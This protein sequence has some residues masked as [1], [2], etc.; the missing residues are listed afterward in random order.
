M[1]YIPH[2]GADGGID[3][4]F[5]MVTDITERKRAEAANAR[6]AAI[7]S[8]SPDAVMSF[9]PDGLI[10]SWNAAAESLFDYTEAEA[11]GAYA[12]LLV[13]PGCL[14]GPRGV[15]DWG[16]AGRSVQVETTRLHKDGTRIDVAISAAPM[17]AASGAIIGVS[18][19]MRDIRARKRTDGALRESEQRL[20]TTYEHARVG[21][22]EVDVNGR[23]LRVNEQLCERT[24]YS[25]DEL[26]GMRFTD[27]TDP[28]DLGSDLEQFGR[29]VAGETN[30]Y[31]LE[32][33]FRNRAGQVFWTELCASIV[34]DDT[35]APLYIVRVSRDISERKRAEENLQL[36]VHELNHRVK[37]TL[38]TVQAIAAQTLRNT[39][40]PDQVQEALAARLMSLAQ[41]HDV[42]TRESW[43][44]ADLADIVEDAIKVHQ[45]CGQARIR[46][47]G[48]SIKVEPRVALSL[49]MALHE[50]ATNATKYGALS[51]E[52]GRV[53]VG[54]RV[55]NQGGT[56]RL[57]LRWKESGGPPVATPTRK[58]FGSRL[59]KRSLA[60][61]LG[62][63]A[64]IAYRP[65]GVVA[66]VS[67]P[68]QVLKQRLGR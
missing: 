16:L 67:A 25:R 43:D 49:A 57:R 58:G 63:E 34:R 40:T 13:P 19:I 46:A 53:D 56:R 36:L 59:I 5:V 23:F 20:R 50:L 38:A 22:A 7:V 60:A 28:D 1:Q 33:R 14:E 11:I 3:G 48:P 64:R 21:L 32:K 12:D 9:S 8:S 66:T 31:R 68:V 62:G 39:E 2:A 61:E 65:A 54:W 30:A 6:L 4:F 35:G 42:L 27:L 45:G 52:S 17:R 44:S 29:L 24:G 26:L 10:Q 41:A 18:A 37:N 51:N 47:K 55:L 15:F